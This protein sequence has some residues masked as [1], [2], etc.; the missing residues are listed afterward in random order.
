ML[1]FT[2]N[3]DFCYHYYLLISELWDSYNVNSVN[4][5]MKG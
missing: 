1:T 2:K 3:L 5:R 4:E